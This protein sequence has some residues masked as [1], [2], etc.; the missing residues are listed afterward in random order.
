M[1]LIEGLGI[2]PEEYLRQR[3]AAEA[4]AASRIDQYEADMAE[5][6]EAHAAEQAA[7][8]ASYERALSDRETAIQQLLARL[9]LESVVDLPDL[10]QLFE[11]ANSVVDLTDGHWSISRKYRKE[12]ER[13]GYSKGILLAEDGTLQQV[14]RFTTLGI[15]RTKKGPFEAKRVGFETF[16]VDRNYDNQGWTIGAPYNKVGI[17]SIGD[18]V[19]NTAIIPGDKGTIPNNVSI[20]DRHTD[21]PP[22]LEIAKMHLLLSLSEERLKQ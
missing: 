5:I 11:R 2:D 8:L 13:Y 19:V 12:Y 6:R 10:Q 21:L 7:A 3:E 9:G 20:N 16:L 17:V 15:G 1:E 22:S 18:E 14:A 4:A